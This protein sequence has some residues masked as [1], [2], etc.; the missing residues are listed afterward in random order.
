MNER[1]YDK[2]KRILRTRRIN[3]VRAK[4]RKAEAE[5]NIYA[6]YFEALG[7]ATNNFMNAWKKQSGRAA[8]LRE[9]LN[10]LGGGS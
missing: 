6:R 5:E 1:W 9:R 8:E 3:R 7:I 10:Q 2:L 4:L